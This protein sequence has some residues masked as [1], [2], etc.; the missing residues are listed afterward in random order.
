[1]THPVVLEQADAL[2]RV[3]QLEPLSVRRHRLAAHRHLARRSEALGA[4]AAAC[5][6]ADALSELPDNARER[7]C[8]APVLSDLLATGDLSSPDAAAMLG[9]WIAAERMLLGETPQ[10]GR[11]GP[12][13]TAL[14]DARIEPD[15]NVALLA[16]T[17]RGIVVDGASDYARLAPYLPKAQRARISVPQDIDPAV[18]KL[19]A[20]FGL[21]DAVAPAGSDLVTTS[22]RVIHV[23]AN[24]DCGFATGSS[25]HCP[26]A[27]S[28]AHLGEDFVSVE[29]AADALLHEA[30]HSAIYFAEDRLPLFARGEALEPRVASPWTGRD[31][32]LHS[33]V[34]A[35]CV[36]YELALFW[37]AA[38]GDRA[39]ATRE[40]WRLARRAANGFF[41]TELDRALAVVADALTE[42]GRLLLVGLA[43]DAR[44]HL[45]IRSRAA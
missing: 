30:T 10:V 24:P 41:S 31:L 18:A 26:G 3:L 19:R 32:S 43:T 21:I 29:E 39:W 17:I 34:H 40:A 28:M 4:L 25:R 6:L 13:W 42:G 45:S 11:G 22:L 36:W 8:A 14:G 23:Y 15:G 16:P 9:D 1:M 7:L 5:N 38:L 33:F 44:R 2:A 37:Q 35:C 12:L 27:A 20:A